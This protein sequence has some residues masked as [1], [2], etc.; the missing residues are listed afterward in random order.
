MGRFSWLG[1]RDTPKSNAES[2]HR[3][4]THRRREARD[5]DRAAQAWE[6]QDRRLYGG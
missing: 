3:A 5:A 1:G 6:R 2:V 4:R